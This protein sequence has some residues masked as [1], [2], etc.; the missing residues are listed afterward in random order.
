MLYG[1]AQNLKYLVNIV[2]LKTL[3]KIIFFIILEWLPTRSYTEI[4]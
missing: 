4:S 1:L 3:H 2:N